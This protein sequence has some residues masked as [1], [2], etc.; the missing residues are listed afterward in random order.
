MCRRRRHAGRKARK[1]QGLKPEGPRRAGVGPAWCE[2]RKPGARSAAPM[3]LETPNPPPKRPTPNPKPERQPPAGAKRQPPPHGGQG[4]GVLK[5]CALPAWSRPQRGARAALGWRDG[6]GFGFSTRRASRGVQQSRSIAP[7]LVALRAASRSIDGERLPINS[8]GRVRRH[9]EASA[10]RVGHQ[11]GI[12][13][14]SGVERG[15]NAR[16]WPREVPSSNH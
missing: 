6:C 13:T 3:T 16:S 5:L 15:A 4:G 1:G 8:A 11:A 14:Q 10:G 9:R 2:A 7:S 12:R